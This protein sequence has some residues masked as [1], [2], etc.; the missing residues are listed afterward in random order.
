MWQSI[1]TAGIR[2]AEDESYGFSQQKGRLAD[3]WDFFVIRENG[4]RKKGVCI[5]NYL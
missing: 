3:M 5:L 1:L 2:R 4:N